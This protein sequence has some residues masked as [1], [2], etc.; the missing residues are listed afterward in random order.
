MLITTTLHN[1]ERILR[2]EKD[3][4]QVTYKDDSY[5]VTAEISIVKKARLDGSQAWKRTCQAEW[6]HLAKISFKEKMKEK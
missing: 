6:L 1:K 5:M 4:S 3:K 2:A